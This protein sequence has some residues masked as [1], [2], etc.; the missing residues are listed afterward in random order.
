M[1][2][3]QIV[4]KEGNANADAPIFYDNYDGL[5]ADPGPV[6]DAY[7]QTIAS[8]SKPYRSRAREI[9]NC[10][11][12]GHIRLDAFRRIVYPSGTVG[13][14]LYALLYFSL[15][16]RLMKRTKREGRPFDYPQF[17]ELLQTLGCSPHLYDVSYVGAV[18]EDDEPGPSSKKMPKFTK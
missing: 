10:L 18:Q 11:R 17:A 13:S 16:P 3:P 1:P 9:V 4:K 6:N 2:E 5:V 8:L 12:T 7:D 15:L 14:T